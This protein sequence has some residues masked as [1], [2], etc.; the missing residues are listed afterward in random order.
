MQ[1]KLGLELL[2][3]VT[4]TEASTTAHALL[5]R[6]FPKGCAQEREETV[7]EIERKLACGQHFAV[8]MR[9]Q[10]EIH[11]TCLGSCLEGALQIYYFCTEWQR[12]GYG[13]VMCEL[14]LLLALELKAPRILSHS[15]PQASR[16]C[17]LPSSRALGLSGAFA[18]GPGVQ[19]LDW[20]GIRPRSCRL[21]LTLALRKQY[22]TKYQKSNN[23]HSL[24]RD[25][26]YDFLSHLTLAL[27]LTQ[28]LQARP[29]STRTP[30]CW[31]G[32]GPGRTP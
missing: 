12:R 5:L 6:H 4:E 8:V 27:T 19:V 7:A 11:G 17:P 24:R 26:L 31:S 23:I 1:W 30:S 32:P 16:P 25:Y 21:T 14:M 22:K 15:L 9:H 13:A 28:L 29:R 18:G 20:E 3:L 10:E 2:P